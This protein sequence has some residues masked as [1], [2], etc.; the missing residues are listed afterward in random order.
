MLGSDEDLF[1]VCSGLGQLKIDLGLVLTVNMGVASV[2]ELEHWDT[3]KND[4]IHMIPYFSFHFFIH[5]FRSPGG[6]GVH[7]LE[8]EVKVICRVFAR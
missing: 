3:I 7:F 8:D 5:G 4:L 1:R 6:G 2:M